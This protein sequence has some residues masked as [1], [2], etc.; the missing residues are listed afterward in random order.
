MSAP[1]PI[2]YMRVQPTF[3]SVPYRDEEIEQSIPE[4]FEQQAR[5]HGGR[6][7]VKSDEA[8]YT[9]RDL[10]RTANRIAHRILSRRGDRV[11]PIALLLDHGA[12]VLAALLGV[13]KTGK[14]YVVLDPTYPR[15][16]LTYMLEDSG[17]GLMV[18]DSQNIAFARDLSGGRIEIVDFD[19]PNENSPEAELGA[20]PPPDALAMIL[21]TSGS[22]GRPKG[23][24]HTHRN[25]LADVRNLTNELHIGIDDKWLLHTSVSFANSIR[26]IYGAL[27]NGASVYPYDTK[28]KGLGEMAQW[29]LSNEITILRSVPTTFRHFMSA[30]AEH[31]KFP[32]VRVLSVGGEPLFRADLDY[33]NRHF[34]PHCVLVHALGPTECL[35]VCWSC[36]PHGASIAE[37]KLPIGYPLKDKEVLILDD[38][39]RELGEEEI[40]EIAV[41]SRY[42]S[43]GYWRDPERTQSAFLP[44]PSGSDKRIYLTGDLGM[45]L[46]GGCLVHIGRRD[47]QTKVRGFRIDVSEIELA[48]RDIDGIEDAVV[49]GREDDSGETR[50]V[51]YF[52]SSAGREMT[53]T[54]I[55]Q[56][57]VRALP[58][59]MIPSAFVGLDALPKTP[60]GK[61]DRLNLPAPPRARPKLDTP[62]APPE[63]SVHKRLARIWAEMLGLEAVGID[64]NYFELGGN[65]LLA[66]RL[67][68]EIEKRFGQS[69]A[70]ANIIKAPTIARLASLLEEGPPR[71]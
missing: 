47:F 53:V 14:F 10:N 61:T 56:H 68:V 36:I 67:F 43:P 44:D 16:R 8:S 4:R 21:Y 63:T 32:A 55:R 27:L 58:E 18:A 19:D 29:L 38:G 45:R 71:Y 42:I 23:V 34:P 12:G 48:L 22:T 20:Y 31:R 26:T 69:L 6:L 3:P 28:K 35:T 66:A 54:R 2:P 9:F 33:F 1:T 37:S 70:W 17:A 25:V 24:M 64:D 7:A 5:A 30:L 52:V 62:F 46:K 13:L 40:G 60:N 41:K 51:A 11:E 59:Y 15:D 39:G 65:S 49:A 57:L 50:L